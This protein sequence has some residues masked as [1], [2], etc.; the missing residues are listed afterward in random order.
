M[1][2]IYF[3]F[4]IENMNQERT[5]ERNIS[6]IN[7]KYLRIKNLMKLNTEFETFTRVKESDDEF[8]YRQTSRGYFMFVMCVM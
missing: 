3:I 7:M 2:E 5:I 8:E 4:E 6:E 1:F